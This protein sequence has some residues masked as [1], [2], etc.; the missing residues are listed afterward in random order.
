MRSHASIC[1][2]LV[3]AAPLFSGN[4]SFERAARRILVD[5]L[6]DGDPNTR[7]QAALAFGFVGQREGAVALLQPMLSDSD[8]QVRVAAIGSLADLNDAAA[9]GALEKS[10]EDPV[11][12]V[13]FAAAKAL[14]R[15]KNSL[16][17][18]AL[19][20][21]LEGQKQARSNPFRREFRKIMRSFSTPK[22]T[23]LLAFNYGVGFLPLPGIGEGYT[24]LQELFWEKG[25]SP[26]A[27]V[28]LLLAK[29]TDSAIRQALID[30]LSDHDWS[31]RAA[32]VQAI[33][34]RNKPDLRSTITPL[35][36][37]KNSRVR[38]RAAAA[39]LRLSEISER[40][41]H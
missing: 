1:A 36:S 29:D 38:Y 23:L 35:F 32:S 25:F 4:S 22:G 14:W 40:L 27:S 17:K 33:A 20:A 30:A 13:E 26:R 37:E 28:A 12:E 21:V 11:P 24:A 8:V 34:L 2:V 10:L 3:F 39:Y 6:H 15:F 16:G 31:V 41:M 18:E 7:K 9:V 5:G 19:L